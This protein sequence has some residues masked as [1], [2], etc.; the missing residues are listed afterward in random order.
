M[1]SKCSPYLRLKRLLRLTLQLL[2][3][4]AQASRSNASALD[5]PA[6]A[7]TLQPDPLATT[8]LTYTLHDA[9]VLRVLFAHCEHGCSAVFSARVVHAVRGMSLE[10]PDVCLGEVVGGVEGLCDRSASDDIIS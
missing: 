9:H 4:L 8:P 3:T 7:L 6:D 1:S 5:E 2:I 10:P